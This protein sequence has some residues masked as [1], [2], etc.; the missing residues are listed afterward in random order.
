MT[1]HYKYMVLCDTVQLLEGFHQSNGGK[2]EG[3]E[4]FKCVFVFYCVLE[5]NRSALVHE[6]L[7]NNSLFVRQL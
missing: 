6:L 7:S 5:S 4:D 1:R 3:A 2:L